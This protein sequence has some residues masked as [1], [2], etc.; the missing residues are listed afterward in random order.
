MAESNEPVDLLAPSAQRVLSASE[1]TRK[2]IPAENV[3]EAAKEIGDLVTA[4]EKFP[5]PGEKATLKYSSGKT[6]EVRVDGYDKAGG[7][8]MV[9]VGVGGQQE[10]ASNIDMQAFRNLTQNQQ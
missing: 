10:T 6:E 5:E 7:T 9:Q 4:A 2:V 8:P 1:E 3:T